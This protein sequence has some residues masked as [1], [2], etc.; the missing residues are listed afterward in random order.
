MTYDQLKDLPPVEL[1]QQI[2]RSLFMAKAMLEVPSC[3]KEN[4]EGLPAP[5]LLVAGDFEIR[6]RFTKT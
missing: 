5:T 2:A 1:I 6:A 4:A 3:L